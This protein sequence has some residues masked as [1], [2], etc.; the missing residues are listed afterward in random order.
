MQ[1]RFLLLSFGFLFC[2]YN[3]FSQTLTV[4]TLHPQL[5]ASGGL[6]IDKEGNIYVADFGAALGQFPGDTKVFKID[7]DDFMGMVNLQDLL[8]AK[9]F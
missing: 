2:F 4:E 5:N 1:I 7:K 9:T 3:S 8:R 6:T